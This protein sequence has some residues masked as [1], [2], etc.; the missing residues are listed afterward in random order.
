MFK[1]DELVS[2]KDRKGERNTG[3]VRDAQPLSEAITPSRFLSS[4]FSAAWNPPALGTDIIGA[5]HAA[6]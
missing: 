4:R 5:K 6:C 3:L 1:L 2:E